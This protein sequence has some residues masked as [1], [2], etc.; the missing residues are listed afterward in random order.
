MRFSLLFFFAFTLTMRLVAQPTQAP[1]TTLQTTNDKAR[2]AFNSGKVHSD[3]G[4]Y[5]I[6]QGDYEQAIKKDTLFI[7]AYLRLADTYVNLRDFFKAER[8]FEKSLALDSTYAPVAFY[9]L[10]EVE[11]QLEKYAESA[12]HA[13]SYLSKDPKNAKN[14]SAATYLL[15]KA[16]FVAEAV[17]H[18]V[19][20]NPQNLGPGVNTANSEYFPSLTADGSTMIFTRNEGGDENFYQSAWKDNAWQP[21]VPLKGV[22]T[23]DNEGAQAISAD[24]S[25]IAFTACDRR[26]DGSQGSCDLY[27]SQLKAEGWS[28]ASPFSNTI[29]SAS[30]EAQPTISANGKTIIFSSNRAG[31]RGKIDL[32]QTIR[33]ANGKWTKPENLGPLLNT[34]GEDQ[35]PFLHPD[36][37][38]LYFSSDSLPGMGGKDIYFSRRQTDGSW[39]A[40][41]NLGYPINTK[42]EDVMLTVSLD[43]R[44]AYYATNR[45]GGQGRLDIYSFELP[46]Y[47][48][49]R[50]VTYAR[51][52]VADAFS[53]YPIVAKVDFIDL[54]TGQSYASAFTKKD[55]TALV[56]LPAGTDYALNVSKEKYLFYSEN[57]NLLETATFEQPF[58]LNIDLQPIIVDSA[59]V[60]AKPIVLRNVFFEVGSAELRPESATEL[61]RLATLL[62]ENPT[63]RI[64]IAGHTD[65]VGDDRSNLVL[66]ENRA[67]SVLNYLVKKGVATARLRSK[68]FGET[69]AVETNDTAE[70]RARNRRTEFVLW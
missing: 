49:P 64:Q 37:Q 3:Q 65:N 19:P 41:Q 14:K 60:N 21:A 5:A 70:G 11:W 34:G 35:T 54:K 26:G 56:C 50:P 68:G 40:P 32:W 45:P 57:F 7:D 25:W 46:D 66:S 28:N 22:N 1:F 27:W 47:A 51:A 6:A 61:D 67:L 44:T 63:L 31:G 55:G 4:E 24:G 48:R 42:G 23:T 2:S 20:F 69:Q 58:S 30:W 39:G 18:P 10:A 16:H 53:G 15:A 38:T 29:N 13:Q 17:K 12:T 62:N 59:A 33:Q 36:G 8:Y 52:K 43:G 9:F